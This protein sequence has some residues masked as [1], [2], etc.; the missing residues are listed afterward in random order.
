MTSETD[1]HQRIYQTQA[2]AYDRLIRAEDADQHLESYLRQSFRFQDAAVADIGAGTGRLSRWVAADVAQLHL[3]DAAAP[4]LEV[5][6]ERLEALGVLDK[7]SL[8]VADARALPL[9]DQSVDIAMA[10][11]VYGHFRYWMPQGWKEV[12]DDAIRE[13][14]RVTRPGGAM[15]IIETLGTGVESPRPSPLDVYY[16]HLEHHH[17]WTRHWV[18]TDYDFPSVSDASLVMGE[19][20]GSEMSSL[21]QENRWTRVPECTAVFHKRL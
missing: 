12:V 14:E 21:I 3:S 20:F 13:M 16:E 10:G 15:I 19:F 6:R 11:W 17:G 8:E 18:R 5:A 1:Q 4:M 7:A 2:D 9:E